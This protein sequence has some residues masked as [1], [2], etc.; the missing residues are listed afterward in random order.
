M[1][2]GSGSEEHVIMS[3]EWQG[4]DILIWPTSASDELQLQPQLTCDLFS[5]SLVWEQQLL[6]GWL[7][8]FPSFFLPQPHPQ[9]FEFGKLFGT[10]PSR[11]GLHETLQSF[12]KGSQRQGLHR[13]MST[14]AVTSFSSWLFSSLKSLELTELCGN[15]TSSGR[16]LSLSC[17]WLCTRVRAE[18]IGTDSSVPSPS[19]S[20]P[21][22]SSTGKDLRQLDSKSTLK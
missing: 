2:Q 6:R 20:R 17:S 13:Q 1:Q 12:N 19:E 15:R 11:T 16:I 10:S 7:A 22:G 3:C 8:V 18:E 5:D 4:N 9:P 14:A 21:M